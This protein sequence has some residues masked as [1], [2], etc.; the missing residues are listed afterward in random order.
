MYGGGI[1]LWWQGFWIGV[2]LTSTAWA[3]VSVG[4]AIERERLQ[5]K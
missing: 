3:L 1:D 2:L 5:K 4:K